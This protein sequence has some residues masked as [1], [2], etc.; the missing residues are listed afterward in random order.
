MNANDFQ[1]AYGLFLVK[2]SFARVLDM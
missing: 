2:N 1:H